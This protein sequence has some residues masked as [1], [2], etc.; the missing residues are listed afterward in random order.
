VSFTLDN[1]STVDANRAVIS[2]G[3]ARQ[4]VYFWF[5]LRGRRISGDY[6][7]KALNLFDSAVHG[8]SDGALIRLITPIAEDEASD[9]ADHRLVEFANA[10]EPSLP[11]FIPR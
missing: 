4:L 2:R 6:A 11:H 7:A 8:R 5:E 10:I 9:A 3:T 1:G